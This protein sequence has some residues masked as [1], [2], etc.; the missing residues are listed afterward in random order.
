VI[1]PA[2]SRR[3]EYDLALPLG[4]VNLEMID[5]MAQLQPT[6]YGNPARCS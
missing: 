1:R 5:R 3:K 2:S 4:A 6:G